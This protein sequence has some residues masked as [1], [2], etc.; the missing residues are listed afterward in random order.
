MLLTL[1]KI[2]AVGKR[3]R[4]K[5]LKNNIKRILLELKVWGRIAIDNFVQCVEGDISNIAVSYTHL[6]LPTIYSV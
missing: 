5:I 1:K 2:T 4:M 3:H 6:T